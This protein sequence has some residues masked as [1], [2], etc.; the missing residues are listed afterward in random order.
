ML[1][2]VHHLGWSYKIYPR[3]RHSVI[4]VIIVITKII[5]IVI[6]VKWVRSVTII[7][8]IWISL[9]V[10]NIII[11]LI[12]IVSIDCIGVVIP[13]AVKL[14]ITRRVVR[15]VVITGLVPSI[16]ILYTPILLWSMHATKMA[17]ELTSQKGS[18]LNW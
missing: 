13:N 16:I 4:T 7:V 12:K 18:L 5:I 15:A 3:A 8:G 14:V 9:T 11:M 6:S 1:T 2:R 10:W 17:T